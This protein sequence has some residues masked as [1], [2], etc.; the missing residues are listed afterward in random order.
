M[1]AAALAALGALFSTIYP[2]QSL[3]AITV[4]GLSEPA[5]GL[6]LVLAS[7]V[8]VTTAVLLGILSDQHAN[9]RQVAV[10]TALAGNMAVALMLFVPGP[11]TLV[12][13]HGILFPVGSS[14]YGQF[15]AL[16]RLASPPDRARN[17]AIQT[18]LRAAMSFGFLCMLIYWTWAFAAGS[19]VMGIYRSA[20]IASGVLTLLILRYWPRDGATDWHD[21]PS[22]LNMAAAF[23]DIARPAVLLRLVCIG[24]INSAGVSTMVL[25]ALVF[26]A[27]ANR[28]ASDVALY[29]GL[30]AGW[31]VPVLMLLLPR[32]L[33]HQPRIRLLAAG[34]TLYCAQLALLPLLADTAAVWGLTLLAGIGGSSVISVP[35]S[36]YQDMMAG[37]PGTAGALLALQKLVADVLAAA[38]FVT[39]TAFAGYQETAL[40]ACAISLAGAAAL[41]YADRHR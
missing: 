35:I 19:E 26:N 20:A 14:L 23:R 21:A 29:V 15:F 9:R 5:F 17:D 27:T 7:V 30:I 11:V 24:A 37:K 4:I 12:I 25:V 36:Y 1:L 33:R 38:A 28:S 10:I 8:A 32:L 40:I 41:L 39:G 3:V 18:T 2:Y 13:S 16:T 31:E 22:G 6:T 34:A